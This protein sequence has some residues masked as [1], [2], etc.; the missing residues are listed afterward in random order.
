MKTLFTLIFCSL[1][2]TA[3]SQLSLE[4]KLINPKATG[5]NVDPLGNYYLNGTYEIFKYNPYDTLF[6][7]YSEL[8]NGPIS[9]IDVS[10]PMKITVFYSTFSR[11]LFLDNTLNT[12]FTPTDLYDLGLETVNLVCSS[13]DNGFWVY[14]G[15]SF[16]LTRINNFGEIDRTVKNINQ[17]TGIEIKPSILREKENLVYLYEPLY[18][19]FVFDIFGG[20]L[21][22]IPLEGF[23]NFSVS[24]KNLYYTRADRLYKFDTRLMEETSIA[25]PKH[26]V[27]QALVEKERLYILTTEG[28]LFIY[29]L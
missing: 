2:G 5:L 28:E 8:Q 25:L 27:K 20:L 16:S 4:K 12:T 22:K 13:Y 11:V 10:N 29:K 14:D 9:S 26:S 15:P 23:E 7:R 19:V 24:Q 6:S 21:K 17:L 18:G 1:L 3:F